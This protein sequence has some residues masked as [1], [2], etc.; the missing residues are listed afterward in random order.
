MS[1]YNIRTLEKG[2]TALIVLVFSILLFTIITIGFMRAMTQDQ[3][4]ANDSE[5]SRG[6]YDTTLAAI[7]D[8]KRA[9]TRCVHQGDAAA[10]AA[11]ES[12]ACDTIS[13]AGIT[14][15]E[16]TVN[17]TY[18]K[19]VN[20]SD[21]VDYQ[22]AYTC[23]KIYRNSAEYANSLN[24]GE[25]RIIPLMV[26]PGTSFD[27][28]ELSWFAPIAGQSTRSVTWP[29][30]D[31][32]RTLSTLADWTAAPKDTPP[33]MR[34]QV[35]QYSQGAMK[36]S[37]FDANGGSQTLYLYPSKTGS[38]PT[39]TSF[40]LDGRRSG[41]QQP[42]LVK[43]TTGAPL[44]R[45]YCHAMIA[46]SKAVGANADDTNRRAYLRL[47]SLYRDTDFRV[48]L[49]KGG[50]AGPV[51]EM[52]DVQPAI[53]ATGRAGDIFR[54]VRARVEV[55]DLAAEADLYP[56]ATVDVTNNFCKMMFVTNQTND[57]DAFAGSCAP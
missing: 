56:R 55:M 5:Q 57:Y 4:Q 43:C 28:V 15:K 16:A 29:T 37:D 26:E 31:G 53:D 24:A 48:K 50:A 42:V 44:D 35:M 45:Y 32:T 22:Q 9:L 39:A 25:S 20:G 36:L 14:D 1:M 47:T 3:R 21:G 54:R 49:R 38:S 30:P 13:A 2:A 51:V 12:R 34:A 23:V 27:T 52:Y 10:C 8:G 6:A 18:I 46:M 33:V 7:E 17:E 40:A 41:A 11:I 19:G